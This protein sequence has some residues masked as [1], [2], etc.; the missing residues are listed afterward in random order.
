M[1]G[2]RMV[3]S[4]SGRVARGTRL[5]S[6]QLNFGQALTTANAKVDVSNRIWEELSPWAWRE[7]IYTESAAGNCMG[8]LFADEIALFEA[9]TFQQG[10]RGEAGAG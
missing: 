9:L 3:R 10:A 7:S 4:M 2:M 5:Q 1:L 6:T 8:K